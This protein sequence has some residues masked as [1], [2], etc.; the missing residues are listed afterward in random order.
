MVRLDFEKQNIITKIVIHISMHV[1]SYK[2]VRE[3]IKKHPDSRVSLTSWYRKLNRKRPAGIHELQMA[4]PGVDYVGN[5]RYVFNIKG[6]KYRVVAILLF[7]TQIAYIRFI[8]T[9]AEYGKINCKE[10]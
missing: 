7:S 3:F 4:F 6:N 5:R 2:Y 9:H 1:V 10:I 8:G